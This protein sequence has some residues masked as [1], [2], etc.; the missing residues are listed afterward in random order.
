MEVLECLT[1]CHIYLLTFGFLHGTLKT[2]GEGKL[3]PFLYNPMSTGYYSGN[4]SAPCPYI[5][6]LKPNHQFDSIWR[7]LCHEGKTL[8]NGISTCRNIVI[9]PN[10]VKGC[11]ECW[12]LS[13]VCPESGYVLLPCFPA[14]PDIIY[15]MCQAIVFKLVYPEKSLVKGCSVNI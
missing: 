8:V 14:F 1:R 5:P 7:W 11:A 13:P 3:R 6:V 9:E 4:S 15:T 10:L 2:D 12:V